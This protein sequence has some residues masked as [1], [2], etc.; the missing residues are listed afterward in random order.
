[1][2]R[3]RRIERKG[4]WCRHSRHSLI[5]HAKTN[6][7]FA[8]KK[9]TYIPAKMRLRKRS[10][11]SINLNSRYSCMSHIKIYIQLSIANFPLRLLGWQ[12]NV[13]LHMAHI[14]AWCFQQQILDT[15]LY[16]YIKRY[17]A[18][19]SLALWG[20]HWRRW[21][22]FQPRHDG[23]SRYWPDAFQ[24]TRGNR[25]CYRKVVVG[26]CSGHLGNSKLVE[27]NDLSSR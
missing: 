3:V 15:P 21:S 26:V 11:V 24:Q 19:R 27:G 6:E 20:Y 1:M 18:E 7:Y 12:A 4:E 2:T 13:W 23:E 17:A 14:R 10:S 8:L 25:S 9:P 5:D 16:R 22:L